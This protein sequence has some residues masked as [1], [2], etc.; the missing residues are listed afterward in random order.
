MNLLQGTEE[1]I[2]WGLGSLFPCVG[3]G[4]V[5]S[6]RIDNQETDGLFLK[7]RLG[8]ARVRISDESPLR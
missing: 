6:T 1:I 8:M 3:V 5:F 7:R 2:N 4:D